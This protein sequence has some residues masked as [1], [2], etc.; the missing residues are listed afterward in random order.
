MDELDPDRLYEDLEAR[1]MED[2]Q[3]RLSQCDCCGEMKYGCVDLVY[4]GM[5]T[6]AC[7]KCRHS[8]EDA[9]D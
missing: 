9:Y 2:R 6:Y 1:R 4:M 8:D 5:D 3:E 7:P